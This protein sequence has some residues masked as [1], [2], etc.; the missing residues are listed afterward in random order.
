MGRAPAGPVKAKALQNLRAGNLLFDRGLYDA[1]ASRYY[2]AMFQASVH[3]L[4]S[5]GVPPGSA[6]PDTQ[7]WRH[8]TVRARV[9]EV[10]GRPGDERLYEEIRLLRETADYN[11]DPVGHRAVESCRREV[12]R[13]VQDATK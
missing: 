11:P 12:E 4:E 8:R 9:A 6:V 10:R 2:Y 5:R 7:R 13:F 1:A 3:V